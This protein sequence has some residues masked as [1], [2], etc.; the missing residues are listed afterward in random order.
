[1]KWF[2]LGLC[3]ASSL[4]VAPAAAQQER[5]DFRFALLRYGGNWN[6]R[7]NGL[8]RIAWELRRR[9]SIAVDMRTAVVDPAD[10]ALFD[11][12]LLFWQGDR[13]FS[14]LPEAGINNLRQHVLRGGT[15][16][17]DVSDG[18]VDGPFHRSVR[19]QLKRMFPDQPLQQIPSDHVLYKSFYLLDRHGGRVMSRPYLTGLF[20]QSRLA[21]VVTTNDLA[22]AVARDA[23]GAWE[24]DVEAGGDRARE[25]AFRMGINLVMY[26]LCLDYKEDQVHIPFILQRRR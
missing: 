17:V 18:V 7:A 2:T 5:V 25:M 21:V 16:V 15:L 22:G 12:P 14:P 13:A 11:Y 4:W 20:A 3:L 1:M 19:Q 26:A 8:P 24:Y 10:D 6:P 9:T 23:F